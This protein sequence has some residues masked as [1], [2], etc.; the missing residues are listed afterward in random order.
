MIY[1]NDTLYNLPY[2]HLTLGFY[3]FLELDE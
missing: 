3:S 1:D 2:L